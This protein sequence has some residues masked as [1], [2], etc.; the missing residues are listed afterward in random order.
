MSDTE[1]VSNFRLLQIKLLWTLMHRILY[2]HKL[3]LV[4]DKDSGVWMQGYMVKYMLNRTGHRQTILR[5][6]LNDRSCYST[7]CSKPSGGFLS[8]SNKSQ[9][10]F[11]HLTLHNLH[12]LLTS[13]TSPLITWLLVRS[14][15]ATPVSF[16]SNLPIKPL[17]TQ[18]LYIWLSSQPE[19][20]IPQK[21][22]CLASSFPGPSL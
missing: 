2:K 16:L 19:L 11:T 9:S 13:L 20:L 3:P 8:Y 5:I 15:L 22:S 12:P 7:S 18:G 14:A 17:P 1:T 6:I 4:W 10:P 21:S